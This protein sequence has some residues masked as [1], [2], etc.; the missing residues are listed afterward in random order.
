M[1]SQEGRIS[2][3]EPWVGFGFVVLYFI[4]MAALP[5]TPDENASDAK[6]LAF[7]ANSGNRVGLVVSGF[8]L[9]L[10]ALCLMSFITSVWCR[11]R[12]A[13]SGD[14][15]PLPLLAAGVSAACIAIA[16]VMN[17]AVAGA[18]AFGHLHEP[19][20]AL[21]RFSDSYSFPAATVGGM[22]AAA[23]AV[24]SVSA[25]ARKAGTFGSRLTVFSYV[26]AAISL[27]SF[28]W[29]PQAA[30][31][32]WFIVVAIVLLRQHPLPEGRSATGEA[33]I[34]TAAASR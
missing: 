34:I 11:V 8:L 4:G 25:Q 19:S 10:A 9:V 12:A 17:A 3:F 26:M 29:I 6:W 2:R 27:F 32:I 14:P 28:I 24:A 15:S 5:N 31:L 20:A 18:M 30:M 1:Y 13:S 7:F 16:G 22:V 23:L 21:L 33:D